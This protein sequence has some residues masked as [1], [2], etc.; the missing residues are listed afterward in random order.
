MQI[1]RQDNSREFSVVEIKDDLVGNI[2]ALR[3][4]IID[5]NGDDLPDVIQNYWNKV[6]GSWRDEARFGA[7]IFVNK[8]NLQFDILRKSDI[9]NYRTKDG[10]IFPIQLVDGGIEVALIQP[11]SGDISYGLKR[12]I[13]T[14]VARLLF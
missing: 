7:V 10:M 13:R 4:F 3:P 2:Y 6:P 9:H 14:Q 11:F 12:R 1:L 8:G 5:V